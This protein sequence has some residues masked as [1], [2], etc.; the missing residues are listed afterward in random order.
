MVAENFFFDLSNQKYLFSS[1]EILGE[2]LVIQK[3]KEK[4]ISCKSSKL[5]SES[6]VTNE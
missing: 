1:L 5:P 4:Q 6:F 3:K 2:K